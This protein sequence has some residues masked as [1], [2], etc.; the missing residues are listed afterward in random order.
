MED[1]IKTYRK[2]YDAVEANIIRS[3]LLDNDIECFLT[4]E[5]TTYLLW[6]IAPAH[7]G[8]R[9]MMKKKDFERADL[10]LSQI[11]NVDIM[12]FSDSEFKCPYCSSTNVSY[13]PSTKRRLSFVGIFL[14]IITFTP[15]PFAN[16]VFHCHQCGHEFKKIKATNANKRV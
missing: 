12:E 14:S 16:K 11:I 3:K 7:G 13:G 10:V 15:S 4:D 9:L 5:N 6:Y 8:V 1:E 2:F